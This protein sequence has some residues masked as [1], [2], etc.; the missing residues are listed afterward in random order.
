MTTRETTDETAR[1]TAPFETAEVRWFAPGPIPD[2]V[3]AWFD[4]LG[5]AAAPASRTDRYLVPV[6]ADE[7]GVKLREGRLEVKQRVRSLGPE[8]LGAAEGVVETWRK[9]G[10]ALAPHAAAP[11]AASGWV[12]VEKTRRLRGFALDAGGA[13]APVPPE[14]QYADGA[15][16]LELSTLVVEGAAFWSVCLEANGAD[17]AARLGT[18]RRVGRRVLA[19]APEGAL[20]RAR[21]VGYPAWLASRP[22]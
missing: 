21:S 2:A 1:E 15:V 14:D 3:A 20:P 11:S 4:A 19:A 12:D 16:A 10:L 9:W 13:L 5:P 18:L 6:S 8:V 22:A 7:P 17:E